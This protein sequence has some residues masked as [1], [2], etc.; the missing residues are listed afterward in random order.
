MLVTAA[1]VALATVGHVMNL[2]VFFLIFFFFETQCIV[3]T[4]MASLVRGG[5]GVGL[6]VV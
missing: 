6:H 3:A 4:E 2:N 1:H 5:I